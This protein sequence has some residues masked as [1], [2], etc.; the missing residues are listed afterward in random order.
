MLAVNLGE[1]GEQEGKHTIEIMKTLGVTTSQSSPRT[2]MSLTTTISPSTDLSWRCSRTGEAETAT[3]P[4]KALARIENLIF[5][6]V[7]ARSCR[8]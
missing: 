3:V 2:I 5:E 1:A 6:G 8:P 4:T 7:A